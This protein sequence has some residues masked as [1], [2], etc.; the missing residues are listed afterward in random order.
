MR[1]SGRAS[2]YTISAD[3]LSKLAANDSSILEPEADADLDDEDFIP[4]AD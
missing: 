4:E 2:F 1:F 3:L